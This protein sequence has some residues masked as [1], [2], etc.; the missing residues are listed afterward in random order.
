MS[1][2]AK[3]NAFLKHSS[4][5]NEKRSDLGQ[6]FKDL[7]KI[8]GVLAGDAVNLLQEN[9][10]H[11]YAKGIKQAKKIEKGI[12]SQVRNNPLQA[13]LVVAGIGLVLGVLWNRR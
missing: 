1:A 9:A 13:L 8:T 7:S 2:I 4:E 5:F 10:S 3:E 6:D 12:E 11:Y